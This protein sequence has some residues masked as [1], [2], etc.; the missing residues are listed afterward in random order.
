[1]PEN[2]L[3]TELTLCLNLCFETSRYIP[4]VTSSFLAP[5]IRLTTIISFSTSAFIIIIFVLFSY[6]VQKFVSNLKVSKNIKI[7]IIFSNLF[8]S[9]ESLDI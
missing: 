7:L 9:T 4:T 3:K 5:T 8:Y 1:M 2:E 6:F